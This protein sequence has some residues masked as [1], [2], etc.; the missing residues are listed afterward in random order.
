MEVE[1]VTSEP[2]LFS[3]TDAE[4]GEEL[5][6]LVQ[7]PPEFLAELRA[8]G[9]LPVEDRGSMFDARTRCTAQVKAAG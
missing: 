4:S 6:I 1:N 5:C 2:V 8:D 3:W 9:F 7:G